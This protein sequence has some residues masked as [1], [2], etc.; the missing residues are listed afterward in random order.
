MSGDCISGIGSF[1]YDGGQENWGVRKRNIDVCEQSCTYW[2]V[3]Q[4]LCY[5]A[6]VDTTLYRGL[7][8]NNISDNSFNLS[9]GRYWPSVGLSTI[10]NGWVALDITRIVLVNIIH[11]LNGFREVYRWITRKFYCHSRWNIMITHHILPKIQYA[12]IYTLRYFK[13]II[14][15]IINDFDK[16]D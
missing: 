8:Q 2:F 4:S 11:L 1:R 5:T 9:R 14:Y 7:I 3:A 12:W 10:W 16:I 6:A 13:N 15:E